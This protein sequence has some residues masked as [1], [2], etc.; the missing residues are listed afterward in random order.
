MKILNQIKNSNICNRWI[1]MTKY[2]PDSHD[3]GNTVQIKTAY[4]TFCV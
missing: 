3:G 1:N 2:L 4:F